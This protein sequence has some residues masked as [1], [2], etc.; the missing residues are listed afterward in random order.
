LHIALGSATGGNN[1]VA[2]GILRD[3][4]SSGRNQNRF[5]P[6]LAVQRHGTS[7]PRFDLRAGE[8]DAV[9]MTISAASAVYIEQVGLGEPLG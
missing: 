5:S 4:A 3:S 6:A 7:A 2:S 8:G 1:K 9:W